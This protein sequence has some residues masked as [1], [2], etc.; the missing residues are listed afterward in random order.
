[1]LVQPGPRAQKSLQSLA[2]EVEIEE[3][4]TFFRVSLG[5]FTNAQINPD[6]VSAP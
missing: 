2:G 3:N 4:L 6:P 1:M 5:E